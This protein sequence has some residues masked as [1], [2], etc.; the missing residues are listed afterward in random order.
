MTTA[1]GGERQESG[2]GTVVRREDVLDRE[3]F[4]DGKRINLTLF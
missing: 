3:F 1:T 4:F 2:E